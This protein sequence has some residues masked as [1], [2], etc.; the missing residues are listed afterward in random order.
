ME[1]CQYINF[2]LFFMWGGCKN[3]ALILPLPYFHQM[4]RM[5]G[6]IIIVPLAEL[7][8]IKKNVQE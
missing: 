3:F 8:G 4:W 6:D 7:A 1:G 5:D 2:S